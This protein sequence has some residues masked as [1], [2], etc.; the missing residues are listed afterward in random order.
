MISRFV[1]SLHGIYVSSLTFGSVY[2]LIGVRFS[3]I[4]C[5]EILYNV[6]WFS[7]TYMLSLPPSTLGYD[8]SIMG[9]LV[10]YGFDSVDGSDSF[11]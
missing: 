10:N 4:V 5:N 1:N 2:P 6:F 8:G 11:L 9:F 7:F 3:A